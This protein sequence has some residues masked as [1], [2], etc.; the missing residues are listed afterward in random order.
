MFWLGYLEVD[1]HHQMQMA[2]ESNTTVER[3]PPTATV[4]KLSTA[5]NCFFSLR[6]DF[7]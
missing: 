6:F 5:V 3:A 7:K 4:Y 2:L 1:Y